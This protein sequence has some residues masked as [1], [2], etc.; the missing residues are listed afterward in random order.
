MLTYNVELKF[1]SAESEAFWREQLSLCRDCYNFAS[2][3][4]WSDKSVGLGQTQLHRAVYRSERER[5][6]TLVPQLVIQTNRAVAGNYKANKRKF[7]CVKR[8]LSSRL[9]K[10]LYSKLTRTSISL[11]SHVSHRRCVATFVRYRK[12]D[13]LAAK[14]TMKDPLVGVTRDGKMYLSVTFQV[15]DIPVLD[16]NEAVGID[17]GVRRLATTS[18]GVAY[19]DSKYLAN[20]R[21]IRHNK[22]VFQSHKRKSHSARRKLMRLRRKE[23]NVSKQMCHALAN[24]LLRTDKSVL[25]MEDLTKIKENTKCLKGTSVKRTGHNNRMAQVPF[26]ML[27]TILTY[28]ALHAG[29]RVETVSPYNTSRMDCRTQSTLGCVRR[30]CRFFAKDGRVFDADWNAALN[31]LGRRNSKRDCRRELPL[32]SMPPLDGRLDLSGRHRQN[33]NRGAETPCKPTVSPV[34]I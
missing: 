28:K 13:E 11:T 25:V 17:L 9:D 1:D 4:V 20:R 12:F 7:K 3:V 18:E 30:G 24:K 16:E 8:G 27:R 33:A 29:K 5:F 31:I 10:R 32:P 26:Y 23:M 34:G 22:R 14:Y 15:P 6:P 2:G 19:T 21:R